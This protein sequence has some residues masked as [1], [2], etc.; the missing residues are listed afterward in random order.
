MKKFLFLVLFFG[1]SPLF[2]TEY[3]VPATPIITSGNHL[4]ITEIT[5]EQDAHGNYLPFL[6]DY[7]GDLTIGFVSK[8]DGA[9]SGW[10]A[11]GG[12][13]LCGFIYPYDLYPYFV[14]S[15]ADYYMNL[16]CLDNGDYYLNF[17]YNPNPPAQPYWIT[18][19]KITRVGGNDWVGG[20]LVY[21][22][23]RVATYGYQSVAADH[24]ITDGGIG[25]LY[26][27]SAD[28]PVQ[29]IE[30]VS[31]YMWRN[32]SSSSDLEVKVYKTGTDTPLATSATVA[33]STAVLNEDYDPL[34]G[35]EGGWVKFT[36]AT[37]VVLKGGDDYAVVVHNTSG[38]DYHLIGTSTG[39]GYSS[40]NQCQYIS[41]VSPLTLVNCASNESVNVRLEFTPVV[42]GW[43]LDDAPTI[44]GGYHF[45]DDWEY[46]ECP[47]GVSKIHT[48]SDFTT[49]G[50]SGATVY[51]TETGDVVG[52]INPNNGW[53]KAVVIQH[54]HPNG[55][56][57]TTVTWHISTSLTV[58]DPLTTVEKGDPIGNV[59]NINVSP[60]YYTPHLHF[61]V[62]I[63]TDTS[64]YG[65]LPVNDCST[66]SAFPNGFIDTNDS[67]YVQY[68]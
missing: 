26:T 9:V 16:N 37:P 49:G 65:A 67:N 64:G 31:F 24:D 66:W 55:W 30:S 54:T 6:Y 63:G 32:A 29:A 51:A 47:T 45:G 68:Q 13:N 34:T 22:K 36:F 60:Y 21:H 19:S 28:K 25:M 50:E 15:D 7:Y 14:L 40:G 5:G 52:V 41:D 59:A 56:H 62:Q 48:G 42:L 44:S 3:H 53:G 46:G 43:P 12:S 20:S 57:Y 33:G 23:E 10:N 4:T 35:T 27:P 1:I 39:S 2:A 8:L 17:F 38:E 58:T 18:S 61:G 11:T